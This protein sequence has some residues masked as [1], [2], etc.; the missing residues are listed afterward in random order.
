MHLGQFPLSL[1]VFALTAAA[2]TVP[3]TRGSCYKYNPNDGFLCNIS[4]FFLGCSA[5][6]GGVPTSTVTCS[7]PSVTAPPGYEFQFTN[8]T[9]AASE[10][11]TLLFLTYHKTALDTSPSQSVSDTL[12]KC[13]DDCD[14]Y[15]GCIGVNSYQDSRAIATDRANTVFCRLLS[16]VLQADETNCQSHFSAS[17]GYS[18]LDRTQSVDPFRYRAT[19][20]Y[21]KL[22][23]ESR[24]DLKRDIS[25][26]VLYQCVT[27]N[28]AVN[29]TAV[30]PNQ[31]PSMRSSQ[32]LAQLF[33]IPT[34]D[35]MPARS[36]TRRERPTHDAA[37]QKW[38]R[39]YGG[40]SV[41]ILLLKL[42]N[43]H[44]LF[45]R[46]ITQLPELPNLFTG[47]KLDKAPV[48]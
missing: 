43:L 29:S 12:K 24:V 4:R 39:N 42:R 14:R 6:M 47:P 22:T 8:L 45:S 17:Y 25:R 19:R 9:C 32:Q 37:D 5:C 46:K 3:H 21:T 18:K 7:S 2:L 35:A 44:I 27:K 30:T 28:K 20:P 26:C 40:N 16:A 33:H 38:S 15:P 1:C 31:R 13:A 11:K 36:S 34:P 48:R 10:G 23:G 41:A